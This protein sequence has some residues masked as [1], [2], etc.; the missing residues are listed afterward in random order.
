MNLAEY[1]QSPTRERHE[2]YDASM[3]SGA[4]PEYSTGEVL[5]ASLYRSFLV[6]VNEGSV[7]LD[8]IKH[9]HESMPAELGGPELWSRLLQGQGGIASPFRSGQKG[10]L[11]SRQLMPIVPSIARIG[12]VLGRPRSRW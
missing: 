4:A 3:L 2:A 10:P 11:V 8:N 1:K 6:G 7:D 5:L 12:G 9:V